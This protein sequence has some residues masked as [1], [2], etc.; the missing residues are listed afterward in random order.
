[1]RDAELNYDIEDK[2]MLAVVEAIRHWRHYL[3][4]ARYNFTIFTDHKNLVNFMKKKEW[5]RRQAR[6]GE[7]LAE[8][9]FE[10][11]YRAGK[12]MGKPDVL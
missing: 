8:Y 9:D 5:N 6:W 3:E 10:I 7:M 11:V 4:G 1:M 2:E 12:F